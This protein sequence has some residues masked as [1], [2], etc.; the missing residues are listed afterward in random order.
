MHLRF[1]TAVGLPVIE[2][3]AR[4]ACGLVSGILLHPDLGKVEGFFVRVAGFFRSEERLLQAVDILH[5]G[6]YVRIRDESVLIPVEDVIRLAALLEEDRPI[7]GQRIISEGGT[8]LGT[9][10]DVQF[11]TNA[12]LLEWLFPRTLFRWRRAIPASSIV[13]V[14][15]DAVV[16]RDVVMLPETEEKTALLSG[17]D[18]V[19]G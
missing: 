11:D 17:V 5:W 4:E 12:F 18:L 6:K 16:V 14:R 3:H 15:P 9:C 7:I 2:E 8:T 1:S 19:G 10:R 13:E